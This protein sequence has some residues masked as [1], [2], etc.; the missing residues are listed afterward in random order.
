MRDGLPM[1]RELLAEGRLVHDGSDTLAGQIIAAL[2]VPAS[3][4]LAVSPRSPRADLLRAAT[5]AV[6]DV[7]RADAVAEAPAIF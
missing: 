5:F 6:H 1:I 3:T 4:G 2:V 7:C